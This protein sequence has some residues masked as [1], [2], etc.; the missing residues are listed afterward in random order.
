MGGLKMAIISQYNEIYLPCIPLFNIVSI[1]NFSL[2]F[3][4]GL[5]ENRKKIQCSMIKYN[6][7]LKAYTPYTLDSFDI[8]IK[9]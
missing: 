9:I 8:I 4:Q 5:F 2:M 3:M 1:V 6:N 7:Y